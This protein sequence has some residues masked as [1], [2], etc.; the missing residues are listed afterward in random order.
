MYVRCDF[1]PPPH[2]GTAA[3]V[4][5][6]KYSVILHRVI[7]KKAVIAGEDFSAGNMLSYDLKVMPLCYHTRVH[8]VNY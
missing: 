8:N 1:L 6:I 3:L 2:L 7:F 5:H 4:I